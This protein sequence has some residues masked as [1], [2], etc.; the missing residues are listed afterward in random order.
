MPVPSRFMCVSVAFVYLWAWLIQKV[1]MSQSYVGCCK[2]VYDSPSVCWLLY[3]TT[4]EC[5]SGGKEINLW[6]VSNTLRHTCWKGHTALSIYIYIGHDETCFTFITY[7]HNNALVA[8]S[9]PSG[10]ISKRI[11]TIRLRW[12]SISAAPVGA[13]PQF[14]A[15]RRSTTCWGR[16]TPW[17][18]SSLRWCCT[19]TFLANQENACENVFAKTIYTQVHNDI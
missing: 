3:A 12:Q 13:S 4:K 5:I 16:T 17:K 7:L 9:W 14:T 10:A 1:F 6:T 11:R 18:S 19:L 2:Q 15:R 8:C